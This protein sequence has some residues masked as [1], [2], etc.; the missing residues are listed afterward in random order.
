MKEQHKFVLV[1][2]VSGIL[3]SIVV[4]MAFSYFSKNQIAVDHPVS[5]RNTVDDA[6]AV[7]VESHKFSPPAN[8]PM[9]LSNTLAEVNRDQSRQNQAQLQQLEQRLNQLVSPL[10]SNN[11]VADDFKATALQ[12]EEV[13][14][15][16]GRAAD[17]HWWEETKMRFERE[18]VDTKWAKATNQLF[19]SDLTGLVE[20]SG[21]SIVHTECRTTQCSAVLEWASYDEASQGYATLLHHPYEANCTR[22]TLLPEPSEKDAD[23]PYQM[24]IIFD[25]SE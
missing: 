20:G 2:M 6:A 11:G 16:E 5:V 17:L 8:R 12:R 13:T 24:T 15:E 9:I 1:W 4:A 14:P 23:Q 25:C 21:F 18:E 7:R 3:S 19:A 22:H 10:N